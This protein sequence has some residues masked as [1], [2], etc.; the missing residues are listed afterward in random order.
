[1]LLDLNLHG[2]LTGRSATAQNNTISDTDS[3][4]G[5][6][7]AEECAVMDGVLEIEVWASPALIS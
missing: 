7:E 4:T 3:N 2:A 6:R 1:M 5:E